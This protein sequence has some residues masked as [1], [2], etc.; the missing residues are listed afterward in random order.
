ME[1]FKSLER[2]NS[3]G[4]G[5]KPDQPTQSES[6]FLSHKGTIILCFLRFGGRSSTGVVLIKEPKT[7]ENCTK[8]PLFTK[9]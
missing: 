4:F 7:T 6:P 3:R 5:A 8:A 1:P 9:V 2:I